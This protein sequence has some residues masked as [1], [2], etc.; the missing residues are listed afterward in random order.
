[1]PIEDTASPLGPRSQCRTAE[2]PLGFEII[3]QCGLFVDILVD[4]MSTKMTVEYTF[5]HADRLM[6]SYEIH[7]RFDGHR[8]I[9]AR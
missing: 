5:I 2:L 4:T 7:M 8:H 3:H 1:M 9:L 6:S